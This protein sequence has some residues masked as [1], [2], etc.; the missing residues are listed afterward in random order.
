LPSSSKLSVHSSRVRRAD[1]RTT[2]VRSLNEG[3]P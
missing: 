2:V 1:H 3:V